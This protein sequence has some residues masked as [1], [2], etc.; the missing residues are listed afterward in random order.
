MKKI[1]LIALVILTGCKY[2]KEYIDDEELKKEAELHIDAFYAL[3]ADKK[4]SEADSLFGSEFFKVSTKYE[5]HD[6]LHK[7][8]DKHGDYEDRELIKWS[9]VKKEGS[10]NITSYLMIYNVKYSDHESEEKFILQKKDN[11]L[12]IIGYDVRS[13]YF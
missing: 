4:F 12:K 11:I 3:I 1:F 6:F 5:L 7:I 8:K 10:V 13:N 2:N 9:N